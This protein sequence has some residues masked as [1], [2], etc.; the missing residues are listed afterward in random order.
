MQLYRLDLS[1]KPPVWTLVKIIGPSPRQGHAMASVNH[2]VYLFGGADGQNTLFSDLWTLEVADAQVGQGVSAMKWT[3]LSSAESPALGRHGHRLVPLGANLLL[4]G[5]A[6]DWMST[7]DR[8]I[9]VLQVSNMS[10]Q[11]SWTAQVKFSA[12]TLTE[13]QAVATVGSTVYVFGGSVIGTVTESGGT[14]K[15]ADA[16]PW[17]QSVETGRRECYRAKYTPQKG[18]CAGRTMVVSSCGR[19]FEDIYNLYIAQ[20][21]ILGPPDAVLKVKLD[22]TDDPVGDSDYNHTE[23]TN[24]TN[25]TDDDN[26]HK[27]AD[28]ASGDTRYSFDYI[29][30]QH[31]LENTVIRA[32]GSDEI[33]DDNITADNTF[34][35]ES[36]G[37]MNATGGSLMSNATDEDEEGSE[38]GN[39]SNSNGENGDGSS[40]DGDGN[41]HNTSDTNADGSDASDYILVPVTGP[42]WFQTKEECKG[43]VTSLCLHLG[44]DALLQP[45]L[46]QE[47]FLCASDSLYTSWSREP[48]EMNEAVTSMFL[49]GSG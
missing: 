17:Y 25:T 40:D 41:T 45:P 20:E 48:G 8:A 1:T 21:N 47:D 27:S 7:P 5:G 49:L 22:D 30:R 15:S 33:N 10:A 31:W 12:G 4:L 42:R 38:N 18:M 16:S 14:L 44:A 37:T 28:S 43:N 23:Y 2:K 11:P 6:F 19:S 46:C 39:R 26:Y 9:Y 36:S 3:Q 13:Y 34:T 35:D 29:E 24:L 32:E